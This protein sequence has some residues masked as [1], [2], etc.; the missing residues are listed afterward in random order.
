MD[1]TNEKDIL[2]SKSISKLDSLKNK[3]LDEIKLLEEDKNKCKD[4][5]FALFAEHFW[6]LWDQRRM[7]GLC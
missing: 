5:F 1:K 3:L 6:N 7:N 2:L 4:E